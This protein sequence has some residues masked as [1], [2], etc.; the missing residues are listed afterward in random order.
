VLVT[1]GQVWSKQDTEAE[2]VAMLQRLFKA[3]NP[4]YDAFLELEA[5]RAHVTLYLV[6]QRGPSLPVVTDSSELKSGLLPRR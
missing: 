6:P 5:A 1:V 3:S 4:L 2:W